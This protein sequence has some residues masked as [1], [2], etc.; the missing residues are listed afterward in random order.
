MNF[1]NIIQDIHNAQLETFCL[2]KEFRGNE[3]TS[4]LP[5]KRRGLYWIWTTLNH[6]EFRNID[7]PKDKKK[8]VPVG[9][10]TR[11]RIG[12][13]NIYTE[14]NELGFSVIYNGIGGYNKTPTSSCLRKRVNQ[15]LNCENENT[16]TL[17]LLNIKNQNGEKIFNLENCGISFFDFDDEKNKSIIAQ[18]N[19]EEPYKDYAKDL[20][21]LWRL[22]YGTP[23]LSRH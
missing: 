7:K 12:L 15:E 6:D 20:E 10:L 9:E 18:L 11:K 19:S 4:I 8:H 23:I 22:E 2:L 17:N 1:K 5:T 14:K 3:G 16:G 13:N 21:M